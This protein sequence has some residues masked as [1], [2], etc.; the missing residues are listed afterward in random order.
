VVIL[1][2]GAAQG[3]VGS[4]NYAQSPKPLVAIVLIVVILATC[5]LAGWATRSVGGALAAAAGWLAATFLM[6]TGT[7]SGSVIIT[8]TTAGQWYLY[9]GTVAV[10]AGSLTAF[11]LLTRSRLRAR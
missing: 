4:F 2:L 11:I 10:L 5:V 3:L 7:H 9:G 8:N 6:A 1:L